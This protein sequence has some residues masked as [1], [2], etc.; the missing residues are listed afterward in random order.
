VGGKLVI[1]ALVER[2]RAAL[3]GRTYVLL[4]RALGLLLLAFAGMFVLDG[5][6]YAG[7]R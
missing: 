2:S 3:S 4:T 5:L 1:V 7:V 6:G